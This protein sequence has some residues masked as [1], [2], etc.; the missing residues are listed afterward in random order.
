MSRCVSPT[1]LAL[2]VLG[3][4]IRLEFGAR[5]A[6]QSPIGA[7][8]GS[9]P[10]PDPVSSTAA[11]DCSRIYPAS[12]TLPAGPTSTADPCIKDCS[13]NMKYIT[14]S[15]HYWTRCEGTAIIGLIH[16]I[17]DSANNKTSTST[18]YSQQVTIFSGRSWV[19]SNVSDILATGSHVLIRTDVNAAGT[20]TYV[21]H[22]NTM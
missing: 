18:S 22:G 11:A 21:D 15:Y 1:L 6:T 8:P 19:T 2:T 7:L 16:Y 10:S 20:V 4:T 14:A 12:A 3:E 17:V 5:N 13:I 9:L